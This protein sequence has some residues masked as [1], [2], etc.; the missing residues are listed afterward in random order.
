MVTRSKI[1]PTQRIHLID[2]AQVVQRP[3]SY[4]AAEHEVQQKPSNRAHYS[5][6]IRKQGSLI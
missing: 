1:A 4:D 2:G 6:A 5:E 3:Q